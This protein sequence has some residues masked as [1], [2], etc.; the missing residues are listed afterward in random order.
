MSPLA[1]IIPLTVGLALAALLYLLTHADC[2]A[3]PNNDD[4]GDE[5]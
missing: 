1:V 5:E 4:W 2:T 3:D